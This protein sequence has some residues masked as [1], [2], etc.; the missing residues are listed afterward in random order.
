MRTKI[1]EAV[2][3]KDAPGNW[4]KFLVAAYDREWAHQSH[5][6]IGRPLMKSMGYWPSSP[7]VWVLDMQTGEGAFLQLGGSAHSDLKK[8]AIW[9]CP[10]F[11]PFLE[12][13]YERYRELGRID[14]DNLPTLVELPDAPFDTCGYR[15]SGP[16]EE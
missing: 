16:L 8:H 4:G 11:E 10:L 6:D 7:F 3:K 13:L 12:W 1:I 14:I 15:R 2:Q 5:V 9:V